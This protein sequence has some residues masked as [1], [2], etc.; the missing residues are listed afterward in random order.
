MHEE[1]HLAARAQRDF[2]PAEL[3]ALNG[4]T[5]AAKSKL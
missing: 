2:L 5:V 4:V 1:L 3:P